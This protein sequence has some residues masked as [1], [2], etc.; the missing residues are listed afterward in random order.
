MNTQTEGIFT[1]QL[2]S[3]K[4]DV[5]GNPRRVYIVS[6]METAPHNENCRWSSWAAVI[7]Q[8]YSGTKYIRELFPFAHELPQVNIAPSEYNRI[9]RVGKEKNI[10]IK[11]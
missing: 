3:T 10:L 6:K 11:G 7:D 9:I 8:G 2:L 4:H 5:N 1:Y